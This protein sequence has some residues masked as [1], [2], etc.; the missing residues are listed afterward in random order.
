MCLAPTYR[1]WGWKADPSRV[2]LA[3][4]EDIH[5]WVIVTFGSILTPGPRKVFFWA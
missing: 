4:T 2:K 5:R 3:D 1:F